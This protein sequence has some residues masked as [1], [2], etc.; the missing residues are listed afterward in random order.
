[1]THIRTTWRGAL[2]AFTLALLAAGG[3]TAAAHKRLVIIDQDAYGPAG[4][5]MQAIL[6]LLQS[7]DVEVLGITVPSGDGWRDEEVDHTLR[8]LEIAGRTEVPVVPGAVMPLVNSPAKTQT[9]ESL[10]GK[11]YYK[12][13]WTTHWPDEGVVRR[14]PHPTDPYLVPPPP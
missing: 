14:A 10:Y 2:A 11:L 9:W 6:M 3:A 13:A 7:S 1:M 8:L 12:G 5:N 4:S